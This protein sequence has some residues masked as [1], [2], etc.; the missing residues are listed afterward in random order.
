MKIPKT[1]KRYC[2]SCKK[3]TEHK[4]SQTKRRNPSPF[5]YGSK[6][7]AKKRGAARGTGN[8]GRYSKPAISKFKMTGKK[9]SKKTDLRMQ[10]AACKKSH[11]QRRSTRAKK[12]EF[13]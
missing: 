10:C 1:V 3:H 4:V 9:Q 5:G 13:K 2:P 6:V 7:R 11:T 12:V 8:K